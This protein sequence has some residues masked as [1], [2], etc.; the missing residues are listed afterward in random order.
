MSLTPLS[1]A[2]AHRAQGCGA[3]LIDIRGADEHARERIPGAIHLP[4]ERI[5]EWVDD[6]QPVIFHCRSGMR[7][8][9][10][11]ARLAEAAGAAPA[12]LLAGG[13]DAWR[14]AGLATIVDRA[15]P[16]EVMRQV[17]MIAGA[18][19]LSGVLLGV[20]A[21]PAFFAL[22]GFVG[23]GLLFAGITGWCGMAKLLR[24]MPWN[25]RLAR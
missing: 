4:L 15:Q 2:D 10:H 25:R 24:I 17:Q 21:A 7:T 6:G 13:I 19:V 12:F 8:G 5:A 20:F 1:P 11:A 22:S 23:A 14:Q 18:L 9:T 16:L 3:R